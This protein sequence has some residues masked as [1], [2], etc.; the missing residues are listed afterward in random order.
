MQFALIRDRERERNW[1]L[2][3]ISIRDW[4]EGR[5]EGNVGEEIDIE[6]DTVG[7]AKGGKRAWWEWLVPFDINFPPLLAVLG[8]TGTNRHWYARR[9]S[10]RLIKVK[11]ESGERRDSL[12]VSSEGTIWKL[13]G[14]EK[15]SGGPPS[16]DDSLSR[17]SFGSSGRWKF[18]RRWWKWASLD[19][20]DDLRPV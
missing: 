19:P 11:N 1:D 7:D 17:D 9:C 20:D 6:I 15:A 16:C 8:V 13:H 2:K 18:T 14:R 10:V 5:K 3:R 4:K 12:S